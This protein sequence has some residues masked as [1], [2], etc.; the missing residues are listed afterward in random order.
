M[1]LNSYPVTGE[2]I[3][4]HLPIS[5]EGERSCMESP[6]HFRMTLLH[7]YLRLILARW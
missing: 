1:K 7:R 6:S 4:N 3:E 2:V 5:Q